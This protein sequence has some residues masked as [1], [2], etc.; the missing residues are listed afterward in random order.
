MSGSYPV[1]DPFIHPPAPPAARDTRRGRAPRARLRT[2]VHHPHVGRI[3]VPRPCG[4]RRRVHAGLRDPVDDQCVLVVQPPAVVVIPLRA[5]A[6]GRRCVQVEVQPRAVVH[7]RGRNLP[8]PQRRRHRDRGKPG[9]IVRPA[10]GWCRTPRPPSPRRSRRRT[11][12]RG[13]CRRS[14]A[15][16]APRPAACTGATRSMVTHRPRRAGPASRWASA[17]ATASASPQPRPMSPPSSP[18]RAPARTRRPGRRP[19]CGVGTSPSLLT[20][21]APRSSF[22][23]TSGGR[24][25]RPPPEGPLGP[26]VPGPAAP[27]RVIRAEAGSSSIGWPAASWAAATRTRSRSRSRCEVGTARL[28]RRD[29]RGSGR[30][31]LVARVLA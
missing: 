19:S 26:C 27:P 2:G 10:S 31:I 14:G 17:A 15:A 20:P 25:G 6:V 3:V 23:A 18:H 13:R 24:V 9:G 11:P 28:D 7:G 4:E 5:I 16:A 21:G 8:R 22:R 1:K 29:R 12:P 30:S